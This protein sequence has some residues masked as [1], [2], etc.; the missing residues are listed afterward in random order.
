MLLPWT[1]H[2]HRDTIRA[3]G[4]NCN[5]KGPLGNCQ[6]LYSY[7]VSFIDI[8]FGTDNS[9]IQ[10]YFPWFLRTNSGNRPFLS[11]FFPLSLALI[12]FLI[13]PL[14]PFLSVSYVQNIFHNCLLQDMSVIS[15]GAADNSS[16]SINNKRHVNNRKYCYK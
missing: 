8:D 5:T 16:N 7:D 9:K 3:D 15:C 10:A 12:L 4:I 13:I 1:T 11:Y 14:Y 6:M 2:T